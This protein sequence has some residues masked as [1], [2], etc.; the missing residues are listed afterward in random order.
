LVLSSGS[1]PVESTN[2]LGPQKF[3]ALV[4]L[5]VFVVVFKS[6]EIEDHAFILFPQL[7]VNQAADGRVVDS[8]GG[9]GC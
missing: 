2:A 7:F 3:H 5:P 9:A 4:A 1:V 6:V 8:P